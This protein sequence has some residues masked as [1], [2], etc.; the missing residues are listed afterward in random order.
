M[1]HLSIKSKLILISM[2]TTATALLLASLAFVSYDYLNFREQQL[3]GM[4]TLA[5]MLG[6][7]TTA[8]L[9]FDD[10]KAAG[11]TLSTLTT[12]ADITTAVLERPDGRP[13]ASYVRAAAASGGEVVAARPPA[14]AGTIV[15]WT[16][17]GVRQAVVFADETIG[18]IYLESDRSESIARIRR[19]AGI[20]LLVLLLSMMLAFVV[21][22]W[23]QRLVSQPILQL[24]A[25]AERISR[26]KDY[27]I[28]VTHAGRDELGALV[29]GF[30]DMLEQIAER[31]SQLL[32]HKAN[33]EQDVAARTS[34]LVTLNQRLIGAKDRAEEASRA[35]SEFLANMSHEIRTPM[36]GIIG[37]TE[38]ALDTDLNPE[39]RDQ[40]GLVK[41]SAE[42]LLLIVNDILDFSKIEAGR[43]ELD[44]AD[45]SLRETVEEA[46]MPMAVHAH[47]KGLELM[48]D[49]AGDVPD[50]LVGD[51]GRLRQVL[52]NLLGNAIKF[53]SR[54]EVLVSIV[55]ESLDPGLSML[56]VTVADS[57]IGIPA[58]KQALIFEAFSQADGSTT[59]R[60]GGTGLG[61]TISAKLVS[62]MGGRIWVDS[63]PDRGSR[64][65]FT[66]E[67]VR[68]RVT[69]IRPPARELV[70]LK[71]LVVDD[72]PTNR[73]ICEG[74]LVRWGMVPVLVDSGLA[75]IAAAREARDVGRPFDLVLLDVQM[76][77]L[78][79][80]ATAGQLRAD[81]GAI[82]PTIM[83]LTSSDVMGDGARSRAMGVGAYLVKPVRQTALR[84]AI[85][86][87]V[88]AEPAAPVTMFT[89]AVAVTRQAR[90][91][92]LAEDNRVNQ[93]VARGI[94]EKAGHTV[95]VANNGREAVDAVAAA[96]FDLV[97]MDMQMP[98][99]GGDE[100]MAAIRERERATGGHMPIIAVTAHAMK[101]DREMCLDAGAD[102]YVAKPLSA[103]TLLD[104]IDALTLA[105][106]SGAAAVSPAP[107]VLPATAWP[108]SVAPPSS[109]AST[110]HAA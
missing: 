48:C 51:A 54:G 80:F 64:F 10:R 7:G 84:D 28:R 101:G 22:N 74:T 59:R 65:H 34:E 40:L 41:S 103:V 71:V 58:D 107:V 102:S 30:N 57:G 15:T 81:G 97:L 53:T 83:M 87:L 69:A 24:A 6:A 2:S 32:R 16:N 104:E 42:S 72:N 98:E 66:M 9:A 4:R 62:M 109:A 92:L 77:D 17:L 85:M 11:E 68:Q 25:A 78:D 89:P 19:F 45:F 47:H 55:S 93:R 44:Q 20:T 29:T 21:T 37:M 31:D 60:F 26:E 100:A 14:D 1:S 23:L 56:H 39:Q 50:A 36:N 108:V 43:M 96:R 86:K 18:T 27:S 106:Q 3:N 33:L 82:A 70:G 35:K 12:H 91:I 49:I 76:P 38:L 105:T 8:A 63:S 95:V 90:H 110:T 5:N 73:R 61:L 79:G 46:L 75:A 67:V 13:F 94:L 52:L 99:M 88:A